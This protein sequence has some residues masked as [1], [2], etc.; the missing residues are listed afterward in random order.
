[1]KC[2]SCGAAGDGKFCSSCGAA[3]GTT[4]CSQCGHKQPAGAQFCNQCGGSLR[5]GGAGGGS[6][7]G[8]RQEGSKTENTMVWWMAGALMVGLI[9]VVAYPV[10]G[11]SRNQPAAPPPSASASGRSNIDLTTMTP[12]EAADRLF[13]RV[14]AAAERGDTAEVINF[15]PMSIQAYELVEPLDVDGWFHLGMLRLEGVLS[16]EALAAGE[17]ILAED[18]DH[19]FGLSIA[20]RAALDLADTAGARAHF[21]RLLEVYDAQVAR[22]LSEYVAHEKTLPGLK[23]RAEE[24]VGND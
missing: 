15:L 3:L 9:M 8:A 14:M 13:D 12:R 1:M 22:G 19:L 18:P 16:E 20:G 10:Y 11:P 21:L 23:V 17:A 5:G 4:F 2:P 7:G 6:G 24:L